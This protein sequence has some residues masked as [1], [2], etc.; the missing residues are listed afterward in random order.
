M[1]QHPLALSYEDAIIEIPAYKVPLFT[2]KRFYGLL[3]AFGISG[4]DKEKRKNYILEALNSNYA[5]NLEI[6]DTNDYIE[7]IEYNLELECPSSKIE[8]LKLINILNEHINEL[9][10]IKTHLSKHKSIHKYKKLKH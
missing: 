3:E 6:D 5:I 10:K 4:R 7:N 8:K 2:V 1:I 9:E